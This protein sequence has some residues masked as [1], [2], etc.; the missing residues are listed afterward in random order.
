MTHRLRI[1][2]V[3]AIA[4]VILAPVTLAQRTPTPAPPPTR[5]PPSAPNSP[6]NAPFPNSGPVQTREDLVMFLRGRIKT[7]DGGPVPNDMLIERFCNNR[8][9]QEVYASSHGDFSMQL[10]S[11][12]DSFPEASADSTAPNGVTGNDRLMGIPRRE[13]ITCELRASASGFY[14]RVVNLMEVDSHDNNIDVGTIVMQRGTKTEGSTISAIPYKAPKEARTAYEKGLHA[15]RTGKLAEAQKY[16]EK[17]VAIYPASPHAWFHLGTVLEEQNQ[18]DAA[19]KAYTQSTNIDTKFLPPYLSLASMA[20][21]KQNWTDV[22]DLT[23]HILDL[24]PLNRADVTSYILDLDQ[25]N[26]VD[27]YFYNALANY[28]LNK[29]DDAEKSAR[30]AEHV[31]LLPRFPQVHLLLADIYTRKNRYS[32][33]ISELQLYLELLPNANDANQAREQLAKLQTLNAPPP[34]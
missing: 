28:N 13:L 31:D 19:Q 23:G 27:A 18:N 17:S 33:A 11:R 6:A 21:A 34:Q 24:D 7:N 2:V 1:F 30:K 22:R 10:G 4:T 15:E 32:S 16:F 5:Q 14:P 20:Y 25:R 26:Y 9:R 8:V 3:M 12:N 29:L